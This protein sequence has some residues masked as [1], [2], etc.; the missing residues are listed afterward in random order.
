[1]QGTDVDDMFSAYYDIWQYIK[2]H[3]THYRTVPDFDLLAQKF[4]DLE[5]VQTSSPTQYY[6]DQ[7]RESYLASRLRTII[8]KASESLRDE[9]AQKTYEKL[10]TSTAKLGRFATSVHDVDLTDFAA[11]ERHFLDTRARAEAMG[12]VPGIPSGFVSIDSAYT[13]GA[14]PGH[15]IVVMGYTGR[16][17]SFF[18]GLWAVNAWRLGFK[19]LVISL[20]MSPDE[21]RNRIYAM[22][23][24][25]KF[26]IDEMIRGEVDLDDMREWSKKAFDNK[27]GFILPS[28]S[29]IL[30]VTPNVVEAKID[31]HKPDFV[32][33]DYGQLMKDNAKTQ[34][35]TPR[36]M[37]LSNELKGLAQAKEVPVMML[38]AV[39]DEA[40]DKRDAPPTLN[41]VQWSSSIEYNANM[42]IAI[43]KHDFDGEQADK[44]DFIEGVMRKNR[45]GPLA[46]FYLRADT[47]RGVFVESYDD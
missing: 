23:N 36:M 11:A 19:V 38:S 39:T 41:Q 45:N 5:A 28:M 32:V 7:L 44:R 17:K 34:M 40:G 29:G 46:G 3:Y 4:E 8:T 43:H 6:V 24:P 15:L 31:Q 18:A 22:M 26:S 27:K 9:G 42:A 35:M 10:F 16:M 14:A 25:G 2:E 13:T 1:M 30:D 20:E 21:Y 47:D 33:L 12:G 37:N